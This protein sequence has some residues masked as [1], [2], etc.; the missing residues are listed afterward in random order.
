MVRLVYYA[1]ALHLVQYYN[2]NDYFLLWLLQ[3]NYLNEMHTRCP[4]CLTL[5]KNKPRGSYVKSKAYTGCTLTPFSSK[6]RENGR[7]SHH[8]VQFW[9]A[10]NAQWISFFFYRKSVG[11]PPIVSLNGWKNPEKRCR[12]IRKPALEAKLQVHQCNWCVL[13][14]Q[15]FGSRHET[16]CSSNISWE[17]LFEFPQTSSSQSS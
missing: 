1:P 16:K 5:R 7:I 11:I 15:R 4:A 10:G 17:T 13:R 3:R 2:R 12:F 9:F 14:S 6:W 8:P